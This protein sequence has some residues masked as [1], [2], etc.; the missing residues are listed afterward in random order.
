[1][2]FHPDRVD[3]VVGA[4][5]TGH[6]LQRLV[7][8]DLLV[9]QGLRARTLAR[10]PQPIGE[11]VDRDDLLGPEQVRALDRELS[12]GSAPPHGHDV[13]GLDAAHVSGHVAGREDVREE[14]H[15]LVV[16]LV[17]HPQRADVRE[18]DPRVLGLPARVAAEQVR[19]PE[20][21]ARRIAPELLSHPC[22]RVR[23]LTEGVQLP[24]ALRAVAARDW[25]RH[26]HAVADR[27]VLDVTAQLDD[28]AH[29]LV[30]EHV[31]PLHRR[32]EAVVEV[33]VRAADRCARD[34]HDGVAR[35]Q[36]L[37]IGNLLHLDVLLAVPTVRLHRCTPA[38]LRICS[39][40]AGGCAAR[41]SPGPSDSGIS[42]VSI[43]CLNR[44]RS[45]CTC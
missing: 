2:A 14:E 11:A 43:N 27:E 9:V 45:S 42:P 5:P 32:Y 41:Q 18:R 6:L 23:V 30:A 21:A 12:H 24:L 22:V 19:V 37:R 31:A 13:A 16:Q 38:S 34:P 15:L 20:D 28:L 8:V 26:H 10:N 29:E 7:D 36:D 44:C 17:W 25:E 35:V 3:A 40:S 1:M 39:G 33:Q 4:A